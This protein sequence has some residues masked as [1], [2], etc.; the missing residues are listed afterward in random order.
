MNNDEEIKALLNNMYD[1]S[2]KLVIV[3]IEDPKKVGGVSKIRSKYLVM[4]YLKDAGKYFLSF[5]KF[6]RTIDN[7]FKDKC[8][9]SYL[10][11]RNVLGNYMIAVVE[12]R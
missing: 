4:D 2:N 3:E 1:I 9:I 7:N 11:F 8:N 12:K 10:S 6:K 5:C